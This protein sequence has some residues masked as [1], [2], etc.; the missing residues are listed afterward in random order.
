VTALNPTPALA[1]DG[2]RQLGPI[3]GRAFR[4]TLGAGLAML[5]LSFIVAFATKMDLA[6]F[7]KSYLLA[8]A[9]V[10]T[11][12]LGALFFTVVQHITKAGWSVTVRRVAEAIAANLKLVWILFIPI[13]IA[14]LVGDGK[15]LY[16]WMDP[17]KLDPTYGGY[18]FLYDHKSPYLNQ[19]FWLVRA[20]L[21]LGV[22]AALGWFYH[23]TS[24]RQDSDGDKRHSHLMQ[25]VAPIAILLFAVTLTF[26]SVDWVMALEAHWFSTMFGVYFFAMSA[27]GFFATIPIV[28]YLLQRAG[29]IENDVTKEHFQD[30]GKLLFGFGIIF[31][32]YIAFSQFMLLWYANIPEA[33]GWFIARISGP[34]YWLMWLVPIGHFA[35]P[36]VLLVS[37]H[38]KRTVPFLC[39]MCVWMLAMHFVD[40]YLAVMPEIPLKM[41][42]EATT[43][44]SWQGEVTAAQ[45]GWAPSLVDVTLV[46]GLLGVMA[47]FTARRLGAASLVPSRDPRLAESLRFENM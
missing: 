20:V 19:G 21:F 8:F 45:L 26:A 36:F 31:H 43:L 11:I 3:A 47:A 38:A 17:K 44:T 30:L 41:L 9:Y 29:K 4:L 39:V 13:A 37:K 2:P 32:A 16:S 27:T 14:A 1:A 18:D 35:I 5:V 33:T 40:L 22:W 7:M 23:A 46:L 10:L 15:V 34:W 24:V 12:C 6:R 42:E 25:K 28:I